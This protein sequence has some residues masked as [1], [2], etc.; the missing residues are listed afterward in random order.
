LSSNSRK[1]LLLA[2]GFVLGGVFVAVLL[3]PRIQQLE[4]EINKLRAE[5][6][7]L[8]RNYYNYQVQNAYEH[9]QL[10]QRIQLLQNR[11]TELEVAK[12]IERVKAISK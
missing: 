7:E 8:A 12:E 6:Q 11:I 2:G 5:Q 4:E 3:K 1:I 9:S 10:F